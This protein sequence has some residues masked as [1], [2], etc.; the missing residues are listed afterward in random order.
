MAL[1]AVRVRV[2]PQTALSDRVTK[3]VSI[4]EQAV[5]AITVFLDPGCNGE[6]EA[7]VSDGERLLVPAEAGDPITKPG[8]TGPIEF[9]PARTLPGKFSEV[10]VRV[11]AP[12]ADFAH[13]VIA[14]IETVSVDDADPLER[15]IQRFTPTDV[16]DA[17]ESL[18]TV[19]SDST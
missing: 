14:Q 19:D 10:T 18:D 11:A 9:S 17:F 6:V 8:E 5:T 15:L 13:V 7:L 4:E 1:Y 2:P 3:S 16:S 12:D